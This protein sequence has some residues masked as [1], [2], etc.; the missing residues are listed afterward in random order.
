MTYLNKV[1]AVAIATTIILQ[2]DCFLNKNLNKIKEKAKQYYKSKFQKDKSWQFL[3]Y[4]I[5][6]YPG[7]N[8]KYRDI[9][10][11]KWEEYYSCLLQQK[12]NI[13]QHG[14][15]T[16]EAVL[17]FEGGTAKYEISLFKQNYVMNCFLDCKINVT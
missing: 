11:Q 8:S 17:G 7:A 16:P 15:T 5:T 6:E 2:T 14:S 12:K 1:L 10:K 3:G 4:D 9:H 13:G